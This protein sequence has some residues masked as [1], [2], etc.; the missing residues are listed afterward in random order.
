MRGDRRCL[1]DRDYLRNGGRRFALLAVPRAGSSTD[2]CGTRADIVKSLAEQFSE[3]PTAVGMINGNAV[4][5]ILASD[6]GTWTILATSTDGN[7]C[8]LSAGE[9]WEINPAALGED[10]SSLGRRLRATHDR[11]W[12]NMRAAITIQFPAR[13][14][15]RPPA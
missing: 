12:G 11:A 3:S 7:S 6:D 13:Q 1:I 15:R 4:M 8:V 5:E 2:F 14:Y 9:G 10:A